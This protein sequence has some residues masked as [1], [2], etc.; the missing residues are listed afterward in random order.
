M[1]NTARALVFVL[2][3]PLLLACQEPPSGAARSMSTDAIGDLQWRVSEHRDGD[4]LLSAGLGLDGLRQMQAPDFG[5]PENPTA[6]ELRRRAVWSNWRGIADF[7][8]PGGIGQGLGD[9]A[10]VPGLEFQ[11]LLRLDGASQPHRVL[12]QVPDGFDAKVRCLVVAAASG[13]RSAYGAISLASG[14]ALPRGCA[15]VHTDKG[16]GTAW[17]SLPG[18]LGASLDG[19]LVEAGGDREFTVDAGEH[20]LPRVA[21]K[22]AHSGDNPE[23][24]WGRHVR[25]AAMAGLAALGEARPGEAPFT[26]D[27]TRIIAVGISNGGGAVLRAAE[28]EGDWLDGVVAISPNIYPAQG[29]RAL[30]DVATEAALLMPCAL[31]ASAFDDEPL[32]RPGG[33]KPP[34]WGVRCAMLAEAGL[35]DGGDMA[36]RAQDAHARLRDGGWSDEALAAGALSVGFDLWRAVAV[37]YAS[38]YSRTGPHAMPCGYGYAVVDASGTPRLPGRAEQAA[39]WSDSAGLPPG[40]GVSIVDAMAADAPA[41]DPALPGLLCLRGLWADGTVRGRGLRDGIEATRAAPPRAG[42][43]VLVLHG[44]DDGLVPEAHTALPYVAGA[45]AAGADI[46][47]WPIANAQHFDAMLGLPGL[48]GRY[49]PLLPHAWDALDAMA[50]HLAD[51]DEI[52]AMSRVQSSTG[53]SGD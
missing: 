5:D 30:Y 19:T 17:Q 37:P 39:W 29:G 46:H 48:G 42:L 51:G 18:A 9:L 38:A 41:A 36:A 50:A 14:W 28:L 16:L 23:A 1:N 15:V 7:S 3:T 33:L 34:A 6:A 13:S 4:D 24:D 20:D 32:A 35:L 12:V 44:V 31:L 22:H 40:S 2:S 52:P 49:Q 47:Y 43:P 26:T 8:Q 11:A 21:V 45:R 27:N 25:Q 53:A 10:P